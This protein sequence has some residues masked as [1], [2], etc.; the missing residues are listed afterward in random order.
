L[1]LRGG[2]FVLSKARSGVRVE[3]ARCPAGAQRARG[4]R[5]R[6]L[7]M[8]GGSCCLAHKIPHVTK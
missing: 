1:G 6:D 3:N 2:K 7:A 8:A 4:L 5:R